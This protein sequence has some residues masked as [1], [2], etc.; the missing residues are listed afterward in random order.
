V[1]L[2]LVA[3]LALAHPATVWKSCAHEPAVRPAQIVLACGDGNFYAAGLRWTSWTSSSATATGVG[4][5]ND[6]NPYCAAGH[7]RA[8]PISVRLSDPVTCGGTRREF[9]RISWR[10]TTPIPKLHAVPR[11]GSDTLPCS[12][13]KLKP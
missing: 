9:A 11:T 6:C 5:Q 3:T 2:S 1:L 8:Y 13:L 10:W 4:R 12:F 7:F